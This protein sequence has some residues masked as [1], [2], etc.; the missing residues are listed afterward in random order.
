MKKRE[1]VLDEHR[2][3]H[4]CAFS[5]THNFYE[6]HNLMPQGDFDFEILNFVFHSKY[7]KPITFSMKLTLAYLEQ[8]GT[9][10]IRPD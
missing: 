2:N 9:E 5:T 7:S 3:H 1:M 8:T 4:R 6:N 10:L